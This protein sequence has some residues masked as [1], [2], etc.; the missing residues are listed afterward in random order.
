MCLCCPPLRPAQTA[1]ACRSSEEK[2]WYAVIKAN[3]MRG[4]KALTLSCLTGLCF[5]FAFCVCGAS[6]SPLCSLL[7]RPPGLASTALHPRPPQ[8]PQPPQEDED[9]EK[10]D[11]EKKGK[12][13]PRQDT[14][15]AKIQP[16][17]QKQAQHQRQHSPISPAADLSLYGSHPISTGIPA[18]H[19]FS[20]SLVRHH[21][22]SLSLSL[23]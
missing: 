12:D 15:A 6:L 7:L 23:S 5:S 17:A 16:N 20:F 22:H 1:G 19:T 8:S 3:E 4:T 11:K 9:E 10:E 13:R 14:T 2:G 18:S 21:S